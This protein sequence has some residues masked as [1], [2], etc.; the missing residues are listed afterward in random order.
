MASVNDA[1]DRMRKDLED[2]TQE[3][4]D[5]HASKLALCHTKAGENAR[6]RDLKR[7]KRMLQRVSTPRRPDR[8]LT[9]AQY[10]AFEQAWSDMV[11]WRVD[12]D[13]FNH[14]VDTL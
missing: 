14:F 12:E 10:G 13:E 2:A 11:V 5:Y 4:K 7:V 9:R 6:A 3:V 8:T 1:L